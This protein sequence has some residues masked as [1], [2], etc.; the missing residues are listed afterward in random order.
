V[1]L[2]WRRLLLPDR[3]LPP[4]M[5]RRLVIVSWGHPDVYEFLREYFGDEKDL[6]GV[7]LD[8]RSMSTPLTGPP[9]KERRSRPGVDFKLRLRSPVFLTIHECCAET[10]VSARDLTR[11]TLLVIVIAAALVALFVF[12]ARIRRG[13]FT[14]TPGAVVLVRGG[15][16]TE[17]SVLG[18][19]DPRLPRWKWW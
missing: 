17:W 3:H 6:V 10:P 15:R 11:L 13:R 2:E 16:V 1:P 4:V 8:R 9:R 5:V 7:I 12:S 19:W 18:L 14:A